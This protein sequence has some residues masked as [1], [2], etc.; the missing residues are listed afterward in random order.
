MSLEGKRILVTRAA[1]DA[2]ELEALL[3][4]SGREAEEAGGS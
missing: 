2:E 3:P 4:A 1:E